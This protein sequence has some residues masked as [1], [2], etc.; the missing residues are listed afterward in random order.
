MMFDKRKV[1]WWSP[2]P[3]LGLGIFQKENVGDL[4][5]PKLVQK[6]LQTK[7][8][9]INDIKKEKLLSIGSVLHFANDYDTVWGSGVNG[10]VNPD[11]HK[12]KTLDIR[13]VR[14]P[15]TGEFLSKRGLLDPGVYGDPGIL[16]ADYWRRSRESEKNKVIFVPHMRDKVNFGNNISILSPLTEFDKFLVELQSAEKVISSS[17]HGV[18]IAESY[19]IPAV[20]FENHSGETTFKYEDYYRGTGR[21]T[22]K[23]YSDLDAALRADPL[24]PDFSTIK[25]KLMA[26]F[27]WD[28]WV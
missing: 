19:G 25:Q 24:M 7:G 13:A 26:K 18:I 14:G 4:L 1:F 8:I 23:T 6:I 21:E 5:G 27:P 16:V 2:K 12:F 28:L 9:N 22:F 20:L 10:K 3:F 17:L 11:F 15:R